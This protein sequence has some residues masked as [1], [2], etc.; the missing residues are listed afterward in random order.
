MNPALIARF[1]ASGRL[2]SAL[3]LLALG[4]ADD[5][6]WPRRVHAAAAEGE[7]VLAVARAEV[8]A[9]RRTITLADL[10]DLEVVGMV[11]I[12]DPPLDEAAD[13]VLTCGWCS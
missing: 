12:M 7:R 11:G 3:C 5:G 9:D 2:A 1:R 4:T 13:A 6:A 8:P 10:P